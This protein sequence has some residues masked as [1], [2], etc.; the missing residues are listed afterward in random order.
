MKQCNPCICQNYQLFCGSF[1]QLDKTKNRVI[2]QISKTKGAALI[3]AH[4]GRLC[5][6]LFPARF[7]VLPAVL[8]HSYAL[9]SA[10][11]MVSVQPRGKSK[12]F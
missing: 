3:G 6:S 10:V 8:L 4:L 12:Q 7:S 11:A 5:F 9:E 2:L 1:E